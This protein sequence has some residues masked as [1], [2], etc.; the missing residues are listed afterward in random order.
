MKNGPI[1]N[2]ATVIS[3]T[4]MTTVR[5]SEAISVAMCSQ[6]TTNPSPDQTPSDDDEQSCSLLVEPEES[7]ELANH[8]APVSGFMNALASLETRII[9]G[10]RSATARLNLF[11]VAP[12]KTV[13]LDEDRARSTEDLISQLR[14]T[15]EALAATQQSL[16]YA[17]GQLSA[18]NA[19]CT[20]IHRELGS[21]RERLINATKQK[22]S[23]SK[24]IKACFVTSR[25]LRSEFDQEEAERKEREHAAAEK[26]KRKELEA[27]NVEHAGQI[28]DDALNRDFT[29]RMAA[30]KKVNLRALAIA[31]GVSDKGTNAELLSRIEDHFEQHPDSKFNSRS[32]LFNKSAHSAQRKG[33]AVPSNKG[34]QEEDIGVDVAACH[35]SASHPQHSPPMVPTGTGGSSSYPPHLQTTITA[36]TSSLPFLPNHHV[37]QYPPSYSH[38]EAP[39]FCTHQGAHPSTSAR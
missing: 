25:A 9:H 11:R 3:T 22:E 17:L 6:L 14:S 16:E 8:M 34:Q 29:G 31:I 12:P 33:P 5:F 19:H 30:Y 26:D 7:P 38:F 2:R 36:S 1:Q 13:S 39:G 18:A 32:G 21:V 27:E 10:T 37:H 4:S 35:S 24:K 23:G 20:A 28:A 15:R